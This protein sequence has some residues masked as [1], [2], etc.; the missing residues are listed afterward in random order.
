MTRLVNETRDKI[1]K[2]VI[3]HRFGAECDKMADLHAIH[4]VA[5]YEDVFSSHDRSIMDG[6]PQGW[7]PKDNDIY[8]NVGERSHRFPFSGEFSRGSG[9][10]N[11]LRWN[12]STRENVYRRFTFAKLNQCVKVYEVGTRFGGKLQDFLHAADKL[13]AD[14][15]D[16]HVKLG[17]TLADFYTV[18]KLLEAWPEV[19]PFIP[20][21]QAPKP[22][23]PA[24]PTKALNDMF[25]LPVG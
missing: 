21:A 22:Q 19:A 1:A 3:K 23:V 13:N 10:H 4:A 20:A 5:I 25:K 11:E 16:A 14:I 12:G 24:L 15:H 2:A 18:E 7:L 9:T 6:L 8:V 17:A